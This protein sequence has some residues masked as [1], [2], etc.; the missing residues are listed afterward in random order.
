MKVRC[1]NVDACVYIT[2]GKI[3]EAVKY[4][5]V[6]KITNDKG[7]SNEPYSSYRFEIVEEPIILK[8]SKI[9]ELKEF[10]KS[11]IQKEQESIYNYETLIIARKQVVKTY[12]TILKKLEE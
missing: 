8:Q 9:E 11:E 4:K 1:I 10:C 5:D 2:K 3:Y 12:E 6:Y 7:V